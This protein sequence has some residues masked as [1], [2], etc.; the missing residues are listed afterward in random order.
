MSSPRAIPGAAPPPQPHTPTSSRSNSQHSAVRPAL[1]AHSRSNS[2]N[3]TG[4]LS[5]SFDADGA[6]G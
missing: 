4:R 2:H 3:S 6:C 5:M 1:D